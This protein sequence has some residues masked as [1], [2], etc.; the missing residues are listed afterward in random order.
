[1]KKNWQEL[2]ITDMILGYHQVLENG[3]TIY[4]IPQ[5]DFQE[6]HAAFLTNYGSTMRKFIHPQTDTWYQAPDGVAHFLEHKMF[7]QEDGQD[8]FLRFTELG[9]AANAYTTQ[10]QT[11]YTFTTNQ[12][13]ELA[14]NF[15]LDYV[16]SPYFTVESVEKEKGIIEQE[17]RMYDDN[18]DWVGYR[19]A[20]A[21]AYPS[22]PVGIDIAGSVDSIYQIT[23][24]DL[25]TCYH[26]FYHPS[27]MTL[28]LSGNFDLHSIQQTIEKNQA[29]KQYVPQ[30]PVVLEKMFDE[31]L[32]R[33]K[34]IRKDI[35]AQTNYITALY[36]DI[37]AKNSDKPSQY[38]DLVVEILLDM[39]FSEISPY[40]E[41]FL[42]E[43][44]IDSDISYYCNYQN[45]YAY[46]MVQ[47]TTKKPNEFIEH[48]RSVWYEGSTITKE[49][50]EKVRKANIGNLIQVQSSP[51]VITRFLTENITDGV[52]PITVHQWL[53]EITFEEVSNKYE[54]IKAHLDDYLT[55]VF[56]SG[57]EQS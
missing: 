2:A 21:H 57:K 48:Y 9:A 42:E 39:L 20:L 19:L 24:E 16:Q 56:L 31:T 8:V 30:E 41:M 35:D 47:V 7:D 17:I 6:T 32:N 49:Q 53:N 10:K 25:Y 50:F 5:T 52:T 45:D 1:M 22:H 11:V 29:A 43:E 28:I 14:T 33:T 12:N 51:S 13:V 44:L 18:Y 3:L 34:A 26:T 27:N 38:Q 55:F 36:K 40:T 23:K 54:E 15:L 4:L 37:C 46:I